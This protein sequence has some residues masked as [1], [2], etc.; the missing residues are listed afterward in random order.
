M[1]EGWSRYLKEKTRKNPYNTME[2]VRSIYNSK[3]IYPYSF[4]YFK[5]S[6]TEMEIQKW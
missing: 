4:K 3:E 5:F 2:F 6:I 1:T